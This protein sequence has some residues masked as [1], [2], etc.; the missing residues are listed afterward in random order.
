P[1]TEQSSTRRGT[2]SSAAATTSSTAAGWP[3]PPAT[4]TLSPARKCSRT[5]AGVSSAVVTVRPL[6]AGTKMAR[7]LPQH[8]GEGRSAT[9]DRAGSESRA[10]AARSPPIGIRRKTSGN[11]GAAEEYPIFL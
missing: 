3:Q 8:P 2:S 5:T 11:G 1:G 7:N 9:Q 4:K 6:G 10:N